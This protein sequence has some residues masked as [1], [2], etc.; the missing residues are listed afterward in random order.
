[1]FLC[2]C[3]AVG[4]VH[5]DH[6]N[7]GF[8]CHCIVGVGATKLVFRKV[9]G[10][11]HLADVVVVGSG[12]CFHSALANGNGARLG[13]VCNRQTVVVGTGCLL[14]KLAHKFR[15]ASGNFR[16]SKDGNDVEQALQNWH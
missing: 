7:A 4:C 6:G 1:M 10:V 12:S 14:E 3:K 9:G 11:F 15:I 16:I 2:Q 13:V 8:R 5:L